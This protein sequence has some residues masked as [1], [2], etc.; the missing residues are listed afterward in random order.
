MAFLK[1]FKYAINKQTNMKKVASQVWPPSII[2]YFQILSAGRKTMQ[3]KE[4]FNKAFT[5]NS[6]QLP[7]K[8]LTVSVIISPHI[9]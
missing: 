6:V 8:Y 3:R 1:L 4:T 7:H 9:V 5:W 2:I